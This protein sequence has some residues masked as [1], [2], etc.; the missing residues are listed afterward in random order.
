MLGLVKKLLVVVV[1]VKV[2]LKNVMV[3]TKLRQKTIALK[4]GKPD[5]QKAGMFVTRAKLL[6]ANALKLI[7]L[8]VHGM[9][10]IVC[11]VTIV[12]V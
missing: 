7:E 9:V 3:V 2:V 12:K 4:S 6:T 1:R 11:L 5:V 8:D 10:L